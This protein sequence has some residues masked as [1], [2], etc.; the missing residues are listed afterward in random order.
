M[1]G[2]APDPL[3]KAGS[4]SNRI[5]IFEN[6]DSPSTRRQPPSPGENWK[7]NSPYNGNNNNASVNEK[8]RRGP[9][10]PGGP[11]P[12]DSPLTPKWS[13]QANVSR[14]APGDIADSRSSPGNNYSPISSR[15]PQQAP[16]PGANKISSPF[17]NQPPSPGGGGTPRN[18]RSTSN[19]DSSNSKNRSSPSP[20]DYQRGGNAIGRSRPSPENNKQKVNAEHISINP[21]ASPQKAFGEEFEV[22]SSDEEDGWNRSSQPTSWTQTTNNTSTNDLNS[23]KFDNPL[24]NN[25]SFMRRIEEVAEEESDESIEEEETQGQSSP[26]AKNSIADILSGWK[27]MIE[28][29][30]KKRVQNKKSSMSLT[31]NSVLTDES[32]ESNAIV[33]DPSS[34]SLTAVPTDE[35]HESS[36]ESGAKVIVRTNSTSTQNTTNSA[37]TEKVSNKMNTRLYSNVTYSGEEDYTKTTQSDMS[38]TVIPSNKDTLSDQDSRFRIGSSFDSSKS[39]ESEDWKESSNLKLDKESIQLESKNQNR[40]EKSIETDP[41]PSTSGHVANMQLLQNQENDDSSSREPSVSIASSSSSSDYSSDES[42]DDELD[43]MGRELSKLEIINKKDLNAFKEKKAADKTIAS[44]QTSPSTATETASWEGSPDMQQTEELEANII[45]SDDDPVTSQT[46]PSKIS[47]K[48]SQLMNKSP[49]KFSP[50]KTFDEKKDT[51]ELPIDPPEEARQL[52][53]DGTQESP[54]SDD[55]EN[56]QSVQSPLVLHSKM[57]AGMATSSLS[58]SPAKKETK[59]DQ[60][61]FDEMKNLDDASVKSK[62]SVSTKSAKSVKS[63]K[64]ARESPISPFT[65]RGSNTGT[66]KKKA[67]EQLK[68]DRGASDLLRKKAD[69]ELKQKDTPTRSETPTRRQ[70]LERLRNLRD[71]SPSLQRMTPRQAVIG[72]LRESRQRAASPSPSRATSQ[73]DGKSVSTHG[74]SDSSMAENIKRSRSKFAKL[75]QKKSQSILK[76]RA[77]SSSSSVASTI[78]KSKSSNEKSSSMDDDDESIESGLSVKKG[79]NLIASI[80]NSERSKIY[81]EKL[82][83]SR[84]DSGASKKSGST[85][86]KLSTNVARLKQLKE[87]RESSSPRNRKE[88][89]YSGDETPFADVS[90]QSSP[91]AKNMEMRLNNEDHYSI[92]EDSFEDPND[93]DRSWEDNGEEEFQTPFDDFHSP[94]HNGQ[95]EM[96][97]QHER[98]DYYDQ[99]GPYDHEEYHEQGNFNDPRYYDGGYN[100]EYNG[101]H[102]QYQNSG[103]RNMNR[104]PM[105]RRMGPRHE[106]PGPRLAPGEQHQPNEKMHSSNSMHDQEPDY[107]PDTIMGPFKQLLPR[108][109]LSLFLRIDPPTEP[110]SLISQDTMDPLE[111][112]VPAND[113]NGIAPTEEKGNYVER[114]TSSTEE[115]STL[116]GQVH[117]SSFDNDD[118]EQEG[119]TS[120]NLAQWWENS[121]AASQN[122]DVNSM[123]LQALSNPNNTSRE[124]NTPR[125]N[126]SNGRSIVQVSSSGDDSEDIFSGLDEDNNQISSKKEQYIQ[127]HTIDMKTSIPEDSES[128]KSASEILGPKQTPEMNDND[129]DSTSDILGPKPKS[130][131]SRAISEED[132]KKEVEVEDDDIEEQTEE[133]SKNKKLGKKKRIE[134]KKE[135]PKASYES[136]FIPSKKNGVGASL[137]PYAC[138]IL[139]PVSASPVSVFNKKDNY[140]RG[141]KPSRRGERSPKTTQ[142]QY[143]IDDSTYTSR[144][145]SKDESV[146]IDG[147]IDDTLVDTIGETT[148]DNT[149]Y[150][151]DDDDSRS[152]YSSGASSYSNTKTYDSG[153]V[154]DSRATLSKKE[155]RVWDDWEKRDNETLEEQ[156]TDD[157]D[158]NGSESLKDSQKNSLHLE[159]RAR[160][161]EKLLMHAYAALSM[162]PSSSTTDKGESNGGGLNQRNQD[163]FIRDHLSGRANIENLGPM[164]NNPNRVTSRN[165]SDSVT[166]NNQNHYN[167]LQRQIFERFCIRIKQKGIEILKLNRDYKWQLKYLTVSKEGSW[168]KKGNGVSVGDACFCPLGILWVK[169]FNRKTKEHTI[170]TIDK[171]GKGGFLFSKLRSVEEV[172]NDEATIYPM[173]KKQKEQ[174]A[175][176]VIVKM[177]CENAGPTRLVTIRCSRPD[178]EAIIQ[179]GNAILHMMRG[180]DDQ[181]SRP[182]SAKPPKSAS[183]SVNVRSVTSRPRQAKIVSSNSSNY[184]GSVGSH[185]A[186][187]VGASENGNDLW[188]A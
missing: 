160:A 81:K 168:L 182:T 77:S 132:S 185:Q 174:F 139:E 131:K 115:L 119:N 123:V 23:R 17:L 33:K 106:N 113:N 54:E 152:T 57:A 101:G 158:S 13:P 155:R 19:S 84:K 178:A 66:F 140:Q 94:N 129:E 179:G 70:Q 35:S 143:S 133:S 144:N 38:P 22:E 52:N 36:E 72:K 146:T 24:R 76:S 65:R 172:I 10:S 28:E 31:L 18:D 39:T 150:T 166:S 114:P 92:G 147:T 3:D 29:S 135:N 109:S 126:D 82:S 27:S 138:G 64:S 43:V 78:E 120:E 74:S 25:P 148:F 68:Q 69:A 105:S 181:Q 180:K 73:G 122:E 55:E 86:S 41:K 42:S 102:D 112:S 157:S 173:T 108:S 118:M 125:S 188:E 153:T 44:P 97:G 59:L 89:H 48:F 1:Q 134:S 30:Q 45:M 164:H 26:K 83:K 104:P 100:E 90:N 56:I 141:R 149:K 162:P 75:A 96:Y 79:I 67:I 91:W 170:A 71:S 15:K 49:R 53:D 11:T 63:V 93:F 2:S 46:T 169:K 154:D 58:V 103:R 184:G 14:R 99:N 183:S 80:Q 186:R 62:D 4:V 47:T 20:G 34:L 95:D 136:K 61:K 40:Y 124:Q 21:N 167:T 121:Y 117:V 51:S 88:K 163:D 60:L 9:P 5:R 128:D 12:N 107:S 85:V 159:R 177:Y 6:R 176:S 151:Y 16:S 8:W 156:S 142:S 7:Q 127:N 130:T 50:L 87:Q 175:N 165:S 37:L 187:S 171:Q 98:K 110:D 32:T 145:G 111:L 137:L 116:I 161:H